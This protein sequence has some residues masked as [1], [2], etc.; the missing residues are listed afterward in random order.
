M[1]GHTLEGPDDSGD[2]YIWAHHQLI[3]DL[4]ASVEEGRPPLASAAAAATALEMIIAAYESPPT[5]RRISLPLANRQ[6]PLAG[7]V[8]FDGPAKA[9]ARAVRPRQ[10]VATTS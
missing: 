10:K 7:A 3:R 2:R 1:P 4:L 5:G 8:A 9:P 6:H